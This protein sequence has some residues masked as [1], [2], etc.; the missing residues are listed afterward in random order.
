MGEGLGG[1]G[2]FKCMSMCVCEGETT[3]RKLLVRA[4]V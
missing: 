4:C 1:G 2:A 3:E